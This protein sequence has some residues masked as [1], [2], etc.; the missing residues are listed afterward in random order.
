[1]LADSCHQI[2][3]GREHEGLPVKFRDQNGDGVIDEKDQKVIG[4]PNPDV[5]F[6]FTNTFTYKNWELNIGLTGQIGGDI[7]NWSRYKIEGL[8][9]IWD[10]QAT[11][12][13]DRVQ[14]GKIDPDGGNDI[15]NLQVVG[16][17][18]NGVPRFSSLDGN[19]NNRMSDRWIED[20]SY[21]RIQ[22]ISL[23]YTLP[24][25]WAKK[26]FLQS[27]KIYV[28]LQNV[29]TFTKYSGYD[30]EIGAY[31][32]SSL[33]QNIDR[34]RYPTPRTYTLGLNLSF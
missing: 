19:Q 28:N 29:Y 15:S 31:N 27:A 8:S 18:K 33:L 11:S 26:A 13:L 25:R 6:G 9:S 4:D 24:E 20:G 16:G 12:V 10:N 7:L 3:E 34:G 32:Q 1:M 17:G 2:P 21:L 14:I 30:P 22:N 5:T 23:A